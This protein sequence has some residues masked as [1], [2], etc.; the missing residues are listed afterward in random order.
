MNKLFLALAMLTA[1]SAPAFASYPRTQ[2]ETEASQRV[3]KHHAYQ[4]FSRM[5]QLRGYEGH[6]YDHYWAPCDYTTTASPNGCE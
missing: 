4:H 1:L 2:N 5:P 6:G 3:S